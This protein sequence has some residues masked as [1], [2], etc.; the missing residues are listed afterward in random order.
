[1]KKFLL[2]LPFLFVPFS[3]QSMQRPSVK[4]RLF[5]F[6]SLVDLCAKVVINYIS[7]KSISK[8]Y[9]KNILNTLPANINEAII[10]KT[11]LPEVKINGLCK[12]LDH[13]QSFTNT[14]LLRLIR[15]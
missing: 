11:S 14:L 12:I 6:D 15:K 10:K 3:V 4:R 5:T 8:E 2:I 7:D 9:C 13:S 1:M